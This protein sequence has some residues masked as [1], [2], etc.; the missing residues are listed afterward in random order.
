M[1]YLE[2][3]VQPLSLALVYRHGIMLNFYFKR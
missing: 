2:S 1:S 3:K